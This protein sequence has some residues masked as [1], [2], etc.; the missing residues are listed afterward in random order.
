MEVQTPF[1]LLHHTGKMPLCDYQCSS[2]LFITFL[3]PSEP[4]GTL[5]QS[6]DTTAIL[7]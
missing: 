1:S 2:H 7:P 3:G 4:L 6:K 5:Q